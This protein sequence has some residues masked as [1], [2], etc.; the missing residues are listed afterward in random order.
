[1]AIEHEHFSGFVVN[2]VSPGTNWNDILVYAKKNIHRWLE[3][4]VIWEVSEL[5]FSEVQR[6][7]FLLFLYRAKDIAMRRAGLKT[8][9]VASTDISYG[10]MRMFATDSEQ[11]FPPIVQVFRTMREALHWIEEV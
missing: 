5:D 10:M 4:S 1:M 2:R 11:T 6:E 7:D 3:L 8:A 9:I